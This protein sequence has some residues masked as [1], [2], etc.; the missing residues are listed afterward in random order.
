MNN[1]NNS[2]DSKGIALDSTLPNLTFNNVKIVAGGKLIQLIN[3]T[4]DIKNYGLFGNKDIDNTHIILIIG[5]FGNFQF[6]PSPD[7]T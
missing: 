3:G 2:T 4:V 7:L 6:I 1:L 5:N